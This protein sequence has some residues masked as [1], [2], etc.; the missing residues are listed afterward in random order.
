MVQHEVLIDG[1][2]SVYKGTS[3]K[4]AKRHFK[5]YTKSSACFYGEFAGRDIVWMQDG[6]IWRIHFGRITKAKIAGE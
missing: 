3:R 5:M 6:L 1:I 2:R 4:E